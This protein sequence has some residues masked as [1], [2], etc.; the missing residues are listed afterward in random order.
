MGMV[1]GRI[2]WVKVTSISL[3]MLMCASAFG[4][5]KPECGSAVDAA[6]RLVPDSDKRCDYTKTGLNGVIHK[7][8]SGNK[9]AGEESVEPSD[10]E[11]KEKKVDMFAAKLIA[12]EEFNSPQQ[13]QAVKFSLLEAAALKCP[14]GFVVESERYTPTATKTI[15]L[16]LI[17]ACL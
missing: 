13:L 2:M 11:T 1:M 4:A 7:A 8:F 9:N 16:E 10:Q 3:L 12:K 5:E 17:Y 6:D 15:K 14:K